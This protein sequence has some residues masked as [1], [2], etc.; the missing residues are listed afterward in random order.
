MMI[1]GKRIYNILILLTINGFLKYCGSKIENDDP[2]QEHR[3]KENKH[4]TATNLQLLQELLNT[5]AKH[6]NQNEDNMDKKK[7]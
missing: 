7:L 6:S 4:T 2:R 3:P 5:S 1:Q